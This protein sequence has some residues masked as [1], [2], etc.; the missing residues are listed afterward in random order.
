[1]EYV[2]SVLNEVNK[3]DDI[4]IYVVGQY[5]IDRLLGISSNEIE[6]VIENGFIDA[7]DRVFQRLDF[8]NYTKE[9]RKEVVFLRNKEK[10]IEI[11]LIDLKNHVLRDH[12]QNRV[13]TIDSMALPINLYNEVQHENIIDPYGGLKD[14]Q[15]KKVRNNLE[16]EDALEISNILKAVRLMSQYNFDMDGKFK[17]FI[18]ENHGKIETSYS[19]NITDELFKILKMEKTYYYF[20]FLDQNLNIFQ[21]IFPEISPMKEVGECKYHVVDVFKHSLYTMEILELI[22]Y[23]DSY[24]EEHIRKVY[25]EH[26]KEEI[27]LGHSRLEFIKLGAFFHDVGKPSAMKID[28]TGRTRFRGHE[29]TGAEIIKDMA[30]NLGLSIKERDLLY[31]LVAKHMIPLVLYKKNDVSGKTL[32]KMFKELGDDTLD[33]LLIALAD[34]IATRKLLDPTEEMGKFKIHVEYIANNYLTRFKEVEDISH[35]ITGKN[36]IKNFDLGED[37]LINELIEEVRKAIYNG[38][39]G[40]SKEAALKFI[41][42]VL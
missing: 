42:G 34:I 37:V 12:L 30:E 2:L 19:K 9:V 36:V 13:I 21:K 3:S 39:I 31:R 18:V 33:V 7:I 10:N 6:I 20:K 14:L 15:G 25:K 35:I 4:S 8:D 11:R 16:R 27:A 29:I 5:I 17:D 1:M 22:I 38:K 32:Y 28:E 41:E 40:T 23:S 24:F 26:S